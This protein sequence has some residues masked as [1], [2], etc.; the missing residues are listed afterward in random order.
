MRALV[1][2]FEALFGF[3]NSFNRRNPELLGSWSVESHP[4]SLPA[5]FHAKCGA[6]NTTTEA[7]VL[8]AGRRLKKTIRLCWREKIQ[9]GLDS[10]RKGPIERCR[11]SDFH[12]TRDFAT[13]RRG[14]KRKQF[15]DGETRARVVLPMPGKRSLANQFSFAFRSSANAKRATGKARILLQLNIFVISV[16]TRRVEQK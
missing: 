7:Q 6:G 3:R 8:R 14:T 9:Y 16:T 15:G 2:P 13:A 12:F 11:Q 4:N 10:H 5:V 1:D